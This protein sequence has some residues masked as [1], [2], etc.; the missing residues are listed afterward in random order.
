MPR[1]VALLSAVLVVSAPMTAVPTSAQAQTTP[2]PAPTPNAL[3]FVP[4]PQQSSTRSLARRKSRAPQ[5]APG[6]TLVNLSPDSF[7]TSTVD[8]APLATNSSA[9]G[10]YVAASVQKH[11]GGTAAFNAYS[12]NVTFYRVTPATPR[13]NVRWTDCQRL[14]WTPK[15][16][17]TEA[18]HFRGV[19]V[20]ADAVPATGTDGAMA[21]YD[22]QSDQIW[23]FWKMAKDP[24]TGGWAAC[25][26]GRLDKVSTAQGQFPYPFG[27]SASGLVMSPG[28]IGIDEVANGRINHAMYLGVVG[29]AHSKN[30]SWPANRSD[31]YSTDPAAPMEG[32]RLRLDPSLDLDR[33]HL[34]PIGRM[35]AEAAQR[36]GFIVSDKSGAVGVAAESGR[37]AENATGVNPW[38]RLL[39]GPSYNVFRGFPW[40]K[41]QALPKDYGQPSS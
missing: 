22:A 29:P 18:A 32:Q 8:D 40:D 36:Y 38:E 16:V 21:I 6:S 20:P 27:V 12:Y 7:W 41:L 1:F 3:R 34:T 31:G 5:D 35:V 23:E 33:Y 19:P 30:Y 17:Y 2:T 26:G 39:Q 37:P 4:G 11:Y 13:V 25:W 14:G 15:G 28:V 9:V 24:A 10:R